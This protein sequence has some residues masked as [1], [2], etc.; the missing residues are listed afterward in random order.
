MADFNQLT[1]N[2]ILTHEVGVMIP[3]ALVGLDLVVVLDEV[4]RAAQHDQREDEEPEGAELGKDDR[5]KIY[6]SQ[7]NVSQSSNYKI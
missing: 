5:L 7:Y 3:E 1:F 2:P 4:S 6:R